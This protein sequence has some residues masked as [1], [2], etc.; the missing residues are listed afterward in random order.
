[1]FEAKKD[2]PPLNIT[3]YEPPVAGAI[4]WA[5]TLVEHSKQPIVAFLKVPEILQSEKS[6]AVS[7]FNVCKHNQTLTCYQELFTNVTVFC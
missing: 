7:P 4:R 3:K 6:E 1:M 5:W 2:D